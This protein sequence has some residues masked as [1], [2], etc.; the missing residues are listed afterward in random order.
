MATIRYRTSPLQIRFFGGPNSGRSSTAF[1]SF[2]DSL[3]QTLGNLQDT[4]AMRKLADGDPETF[5]SYW[6]QRKRYISKSN[7]LYALMEDYYQKAQHRLE[8]NKQ[9][10]KA[11]AQYARTNN[12]QAYLDY[13]LS[14]LDTETDPAIL[15]KLGTQINELRS[16]VYQSGSGSASLGG[17]V[18]QQ[19]FV[20]ARDAWDS[21]VN[22]VNG[23]LADRPLTTD[24]VNEFKKAKEDYATLLHTIATAPDTTYTRA[25]T[26]NTALTATTGPND[27][28]VNNVIFQSDQKLM[29]N[30]KTDDQFAAQ[31]ALMDTPGERAKA[32]AQRAQQLGLLVSKAQSTQGV[33]LITKSLQDAEA[34]SASF[35]NQATTESKKLTGPAADYIDSQYANYWSDVT[36]GHQKNPRNY[37]TGPI[38]KS[39]WMRQL[40]NAPDAKTFNSQVHWNVADDLFQTLKGAITTQ[41]PDFGPARYDIQTGQWEGDPTAVK[42]AKDAVDAIQAQWDIP[43]NQFE[44]LKKVG[45]T[46]PDSILRYI[47]GD[48]TPETLQAVYQRLSGGFMSPTNQQLQQG[49][50][51]DETQNKKE[52]TEQQ[53]TA[54]ST[55]PGPG[56]EAP[57]LPGLTAQDAGALPVED[58][59]PGGPKV[60]PSVSPEPVDS[61][62]DF[63]NARLTADS[64]LGSYDLP[65]LPQFTPP[66]D[67]PAP[68]EDV[69]FP[70]ENGSTS[71]PS[72]SSGGAG[73]GGGPAF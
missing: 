73:G 69:L 38:S 29:A 58:T 21:E 55:A 16:R 68:D 60:N 19:D 53:P 6:Q 51:A 30:Y 24:E 36:L 47:N 57:N 20:N 39:D 12:H 43:G 50:G 71:L 64:F 5:I 8:V 45:F 14:K 27:K 40:K 70:F 22:K 23:I 41:G 7:P 34:K 11:L 66:K 56:P 1:G 63:E 33:Q 10:A 48:I 35:A 61:P 72:L 44:M 17:G 37:P 28:F 65:D 49:A 15:S 42:N 32:Y 4:E 62:Q 18:S 46:D 26:M 9:D 67:K 3:N 52:P 54:N 25:N 59:A 13:L 2:V 31:V